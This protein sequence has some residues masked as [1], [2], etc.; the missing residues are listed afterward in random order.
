METTNKQK[1]N[2]LA[3]LIRKHGGWIDGEHLRFPTPHALARFEAAIELER[4]ADTLSK[5][6]APK[7]A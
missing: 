7:E 2:A 4:L 1:G 3:R 6:Q 5:P